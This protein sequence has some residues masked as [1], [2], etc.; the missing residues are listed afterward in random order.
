MYTDVC[1]SVQGDN[2]IAKMIATT[3]EK[4]AK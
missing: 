4:I 2:T 3:F 1:A